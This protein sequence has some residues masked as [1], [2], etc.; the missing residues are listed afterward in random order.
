MFTRP[1]TD[2]AST[3]G[4]PYKRTILY[5]KKWSVFYN[6]QKDPQFKNT[7]TKCSKISTEVLV[8]GAAYHCTHA[9]ADI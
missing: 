3:F 4:S 8:H 2:G 1:G 6:V 7:R 9:F 5:M